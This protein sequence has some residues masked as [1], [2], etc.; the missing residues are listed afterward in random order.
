[1]QWVLEIGRKP[2]NKRVEEGEWYAKKI[3]GVIWIED[4]WAEAEE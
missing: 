4:E 2:E 3:K 1:M